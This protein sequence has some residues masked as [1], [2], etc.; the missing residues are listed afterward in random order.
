MFCKNGNEVD[1]RLE[2]GEV[3]LRY[4]RSSI[5]RLEKV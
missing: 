2:S 1:L 4:V 5:R 3:L